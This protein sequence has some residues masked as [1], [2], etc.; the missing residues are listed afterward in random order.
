MEWDLGFEEQIWVSTHAGSDLAGV[1]DL[2]VAASRQQ[3]EVTGR[4]VRRSRAAHDP[5]QTL[6]LLNYIKP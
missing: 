5:G 3:S 2:R 6:S 1:A 4:D